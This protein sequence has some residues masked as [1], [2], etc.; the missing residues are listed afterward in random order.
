[1]FGGERTE[2][3]VEIL[4]LS[5]E[6]DRRYVPTLRAAF[7]R[8]IAARC[9]ALILDLTEVYDID[10]SAIATL[11]EYYR[12]AGRHG[13]V[14]C[15]CGVNEGLKP[16]LAAVELGDSLAMF[17]SVADAVAAIRR[18]EIQPYGYAAPTTQP[19]TDIPARILSR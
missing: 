11:V 4:G 16:M 19:D 9:Q 17:D 13:G 14:L 8:K 3:G 7:R 15:L 6:I 10:S 1:M 12:D 2:C 5:C 18:S